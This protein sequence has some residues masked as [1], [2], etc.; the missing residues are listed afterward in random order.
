M[1][2]NMLP[3]LNILYDYCNLNSKKESMYKYVTIFITLHNTYY[4]ILHISSAM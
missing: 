3:F 1:Y 4:Y 2:Y